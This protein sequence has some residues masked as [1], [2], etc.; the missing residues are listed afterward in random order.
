MLNPRMT[1]LKWLLHGIPS[2][3]WSIDYLN[4]SIVDCEPI[5]LKYKNILGGPWRAS[6]LE[7]I[8]KLLIQ[9]NIDVITTHHISLNKIRTFTYSISIYLLLLFN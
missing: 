5:P 1:L 4:T 2:D 6:S 9:L 8:G 7:T 3:L